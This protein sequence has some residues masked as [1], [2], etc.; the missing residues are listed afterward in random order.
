M[1]QGCGLGLPHTH[2][3]SEGVPGPQ[4]AGG[5]LI[6]TQTHSAQRGWITHPPTKCG[7][8]PT[9][10]CPLSDLA[11]SPPS[12][13]G[14]LVLRPPRE[15]V[16]VSLACPNPPRAQ[17]PRAP[18]PL[19]PGPPGLLASQ[20][21][22]PPRTH[23]WAGA[24]PLTRTR[25]RGISCERRAGG[26]H[27]DVTRVCSSPWQ[28]QPASDETGGIRGTA[29]SGRGGALTPGQGGPAENLWE[30]GG[31]RP[32]PRPP[33]SAPVCWCW[34][35]GCHVAGPRVTH[36]QARGGASGALRSPSRGLWM[37]LTQLSLPQAVS[38]ADGRGAGPWQEWAARGRGPVWLGFS[39]ASGALCCPQAML[40]GPG[41][42]GSDGLEGSS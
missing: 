23:S 35:K 2:T 21:S 9:A 3:A 25:L 11:A 14:V 10:T 36:V 40:P 1:L 6:Q 13:N 39:E 16:E 18:S 7:F 30:E 32:V 31:H 34:Q 24:P 37:T 27:Q 15:G 29:G 41:E 5:P 28:G 22:R 33:A 4:P 42:P 20:D 19:A 8:T 17:P 26:T 38:T 12:V